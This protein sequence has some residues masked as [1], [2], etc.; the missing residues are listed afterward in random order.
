ME[1]GCVSVCSVCGVVGSSRKEER[2]SSGSEAERRCVPQM[3][4]HFARAAA[5]EGKRLRAGGKLVREPP[6]N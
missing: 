4:G 2:V 5:G 6:A 1:A 3:N